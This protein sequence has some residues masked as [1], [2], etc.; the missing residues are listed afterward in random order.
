MKNN[1]F[2]S[3]ISSAN[4]F[5]NGAETIANADKKIS[6]AFSDFD[7]TLVRSD[8]VLS[9]VT[10]ARIEKFKRAGGF[11]AVCTGRMT[12]AILPICREYGLGDYVISFQGAAI[13]EV[14]SGKCI[15]FNPVEVR[16]A[17]A[18]AD[19]AKK[20]GRN[21]QVYVG[22]GF[23]SR[24]RDEQTDAYASVASLEYASHEN[25]GDYLRELNEPTGKALFY[26]GSENPE[27]LRDEI[28]EVAGDKYNVFISNPRQIDVIKA[29]VSKGTGVKRLLSLAGLSG[30]P[31]MCCGDESNDI[32]MLKIADLPV[33][34]ANA[35]A[36]VKSV[37]KYVTSSNDEDG[38]AKALKLFCV[39]E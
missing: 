33:A 16:D 9:P 15:Y 1:D 7:G 34:T 19:Y 13:N 38:V 4:G 2:I 5:K 18:L 39:G 35:E 20:T 6:V 17:A 27:R 23:V 36:C 31:F 26:I 10:L 11:F 22:G 24:L 29:G 8:I 30:E 3:S 32:S 12:S 21:M 37:A 28:A 25:L 14:K